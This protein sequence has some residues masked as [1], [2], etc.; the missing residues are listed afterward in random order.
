M[1]VEMLMYVEHIHY[2]NVTLNVLNIQFNYLKY[3]S[4]Y[5]NNYNL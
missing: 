4:Y 2:D 5:Y 1:C 3:K